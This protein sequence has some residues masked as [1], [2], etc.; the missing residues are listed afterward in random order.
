MARTRT[1]HAAPPDPEP[2]PADR[3]HAMIREAAYFLY[4]SSDREPGRDLDHWLA[5]EA[6]IDDRLSG[7]SL[8]VEATAI[9]RAGRAKPDRTRRSRATDAG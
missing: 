7:E 1:R 8:S 2:T 6:L 3:R 4:L 5:A 9:L